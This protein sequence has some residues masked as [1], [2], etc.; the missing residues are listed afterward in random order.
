MQAFA[1]I[2]IAW[3]G[4]GWDID[5]VGDEVFYHYLVSKVRIQ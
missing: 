2:C 1:L 4:V 5:G 3:E